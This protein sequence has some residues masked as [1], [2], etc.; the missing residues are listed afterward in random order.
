MKKVLIDIIP[1]LIGI[2]LALFISN[3]Q[4]SASERT[5]IENSI[6]AIILENESNI[7]ELEYA[8]GRQRQLLDTL[9]QYLLEDGMS[10]ATAVYKGNG[11]YTPD[12][13][14]T[15]WGFLVQDSKHTLVTYEY[16]TRLAE[17]EKY[18]TLLR[19]FNTKVTDLFYQPAYYT[20]PIMKRVCHGMISDLMGVEKSFI[21]ALQDFN[22]YAKSAQL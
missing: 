12:L 11:L 6:Q 2:L 19:R 17:V 9:N 22:E 20:D 4:Q 14:S 10:L 7:E 15:T 21:Q 18:E 13:K 16:I 3:W 5:Y 8:L 1:V